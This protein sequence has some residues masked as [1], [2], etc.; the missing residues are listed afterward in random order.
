MNTKIYS[1]VNKM[2]SWQKTLKPYA[3]Q[4]KSRDYSHN[5]RFT[6]KMSGRK[7]S[8]FDSKDWARDQIE[9]DWKESAAGFTGALIA[10]GIY[11]ISYPVTFIDGPLPFVDAAWAYGLLRITKA[12]YDTGEFIGSLFF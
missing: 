11:S 4:L 2:E 8:T 1:G 7:G 9:K 12:G 3:D 10:A 6:R 5:L